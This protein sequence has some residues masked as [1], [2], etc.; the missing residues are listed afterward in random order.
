MRLCIKNLRLIISLACL[1][2]GQAFAQTTLVVPAPH[3]VTSDIGVE[4]ESTLVSIVTR[5]NWYVVPYGLYGSGLSKYKYGG[6]LGYF[7]PLNR[8]AVAGTRLE[9]LNGDFWMP[10]ISGTLQLPLRIGK[11]IEVTPLTFTGI[12][13]P[14][15]GGK[16]F[17]LQL[18][19]HAR[20]N[21]GST[22]TIFGIGLGIHVVDLGHYELGGVAD[23]ETWSGFPGHQWRFGLTLHHK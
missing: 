2:A 3:K 23:Y 1:I 9:Y 22:S 21:N 18:P 6:G 14:I 20:D 13:I 15:T 17:G 10:D 7:Y 5:T 16:V 12:G 19:G 11:Y 4:G 8:F